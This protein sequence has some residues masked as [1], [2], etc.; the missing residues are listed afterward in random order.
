MGAAKFLRTVNPESISSNSFTLL[1]LTRT[2][3]MFYGD[4]LNGNDNATV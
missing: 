3:A 4:H 1:L 2:L